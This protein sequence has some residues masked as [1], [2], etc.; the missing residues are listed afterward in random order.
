MGFP[1]TPDKLIDSVYDLD[2]DDLA[3]RGVRLILADLDN[4][5]ARYGE[6]KPS[7]RLRE[8]AKEVE[9]RGM[10]LFVLSN[11]RK[12]RR[13]KTFCEGFV[14]YLSHASKPHARNFHKV[15]E[16]Y[17]CTPEETI[18]LG[19]QIFTDV[20]G[21]HNAG[22]RAAIYVRAIA[23]DSLPRKLRYGVEAPFRG[24]C[25]LRGDKL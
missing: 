3:A 14:P 9:R 5:L 20:W 17:G 13:S 22:V 10:T 1:L 7:P 21:G 19:D 4:T 24:L 8:W 11:G 18:M 25:R 15:M 2:L 6:A 23:L 16:E 12:P